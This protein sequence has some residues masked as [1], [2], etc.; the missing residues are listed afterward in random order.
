MAVLDVARCFKRIIRIACSLWAVQYSISDWIKGHP[1]HDGLLNQLVG[2]SID[3]NHASLAKV[4]FMIFDVSFIRS[5]SRQCIDRQRVHGRHHGHRHRCGR[6]TTRD[7]IECLKLF[8]QLTPADLS[9]FSHSSLELT[10]HAILRHHLLTFPQTQ[11]RSYQE[12]PKILD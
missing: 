7:F 3:V 11:S 12:Y 5:A 9:C 1:S 6:K 10:P 2:L 8:I 4:R